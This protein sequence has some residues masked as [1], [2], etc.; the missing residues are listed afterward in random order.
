MYNAMNLTPTKFIKHQVVRIK[1]FRRDEVPPYWVGSML[2][3]RGAIVTIREPGSKF[4]ISED[5]GYIWH[6]TDFEKVNTNV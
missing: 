2:N 1:R 5:S 6:D 3:M 4:H